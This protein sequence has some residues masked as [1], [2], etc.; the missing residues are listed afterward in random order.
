M[1]Q[2]SMMACWSHAVDAVSRIPLSF[3]GNGMARMEKACAAAID[4]PRLPLQN[5]SGSATAD[6][7]RASV[8]GASLALAPPTHARS[9]PALLP[10]LIIAPLSPSL[11]CE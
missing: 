9:T 7:S 6:Q 4:A 8:G 2:P 5:D 11:A 1:I 10:R 3:P